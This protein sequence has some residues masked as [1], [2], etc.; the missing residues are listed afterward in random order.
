MLSFGG[1]VP[2]PR[3]GC[4]SDASL[5][6]AGPPLT[7]LAPSQVPIPEPTAELQEACVRLLV[8][9]SEHS[10][11]FNFL[12]VGVVKALGGG[13]FSFLPFSGRNPSLRRAKART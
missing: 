6:A 3:A 10:R 9:S 1:G 12:A 7:R 13:D 2:V 4:W 5:A 11:C 8:G